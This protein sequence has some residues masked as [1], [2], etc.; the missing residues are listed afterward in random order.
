MTE[1]NNDQRDNRAEYRQDTVL[2]HEYDGIQE[3]DNRL[4]NWWMWIM[5]GS[6][7]FA[8][9]YWIFFHTLGVGE[10]PRERFA[11]DMQVA[12]E[13]QL[14]RALAAGIDNEFFV[15]MSQT[16][17]N[18]AAGREIFVKHC[19]QCHLDDGRGSVGPNLTDSYWVHGCEPMQMLKTLNEGVA[20][21]GMPAWQ[22][23]LGPTRVHNVLA[24]ILTIKDN[25]LVGKA[26]EG[27]PCTF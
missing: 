27:D 2:E 17:S 4:P 26:P 13:A 12:Q 25:N 20:A 3:F 9:F 14:E 19:V 15:M 7:V 8:L 6:M 18:V 21:K 22:N 1:H 24:Y 11:R 16:E 5:W 23:Q 10:L